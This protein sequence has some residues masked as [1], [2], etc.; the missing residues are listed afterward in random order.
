MPDWETLKSDV[1]VTEVSVSLTEML[2]TTTTPDVFKLELVGSE[3][4]AWAKEVVISDRVETADESKSVVSTEVAVVPVMIEDSD[5]VVVSGKVEG[6]DNEDSDEK[7]ESGEV[8][9]FD[10]LS[11]RETADSVELVSGARV[12]C[13][14]AVVSD[15]V[16]GS[17][18]DVV[19][20][21][22]SEDTAVCAVV[23]F[24]EIIVVELSDSSDDD[25]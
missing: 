23:K 6:V 9:E 11:D 18:D 22:V 5:K 19:V 16:V 4:A 7:I 14:V 20:I 24:G 8:I 10:V 13:G 25:A 15:E 1:L 12:C 21:V 17:D 2:E 3:L